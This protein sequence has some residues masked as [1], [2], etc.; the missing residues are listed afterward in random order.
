MEV[1]TEVESREIG[2]T[3]VLTLFWHFG[4]A[5]PV[6]AQCPEF[7]SLA[8]AC[9]GGL[10][11]QKENSLKYYYLIPLQLALGIAVVR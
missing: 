8:T 5:C 10:N 6:R 7:S 2:K 1:K 9:E 4:S 11:L 3:F